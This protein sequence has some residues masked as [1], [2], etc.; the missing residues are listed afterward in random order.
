MYH[1]ETTLCTTP[2]QGLLARHPST[3][4]EFSWDEHNEGKL[5]E[6]DIRPEDVETV[7]L[8]D[9]QIFKNKR[10]GTAAWMMVGKDGRGR[11]LKIGVLW[12]D[13][14]HGVLRAITAWEVK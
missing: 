12:A 10:S 9:P 4:S 8:S 7:F 6:R 11:T 2:G 13:E 5:L 1:T 14:R 3:A